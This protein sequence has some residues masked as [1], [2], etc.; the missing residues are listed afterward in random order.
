LG[1]EMRLRAKHK[2]KMY[3]GAID[4]Q[5]LL[6]DMLGKEAI[7]REDR[8][9]QNGEDAPMP[10]SEGAQMVANRILKNLKRLKKW[11]NQSGVTCYRVYDADMPEYAAAIDVYED[12]YHVQEY[13]APKS[14]N[15]KKAHQRFDEILRAT[16][17]VFGSDF[18][19][20]IAKTRQRNRGK[21]QYQ[22]FNN[23]GD[24]TYF[25]VQ[26]DRAKL[27]VN[28]S[29]YLDTGLFLDHRPLRRMILQQANGKRFLN[30]FCY[31]AT[32]TVQ[33]ALG[34][35]ASSVSV[36]MS[37]TYLDWAA[38]N[39]ELN[40]LSAARHKLVR[41]DGVEW[42]R[43]C[44]EGF[45]LIMLDPPTFSNSK[46]TDTVLD[47]QR[48]HSSLI[49]RC[50]DLLTPTGTLYF[51]NNLRSFKLDEGLQAKFQIK[52]ISAD[53]LDPDFERNPKIHNCW[54]ICHC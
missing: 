40:N 28:L 33:A 2:Y 42:L 54:Q 36:D 16:A 23:D 24:S 31:T 5:L 12:Y 3:N 26:E 46:N 37:N 35:A 25:N 21:K 29:D 10:L 30:L 20:V 45:D 43:N 52:N 18:D 44:R 49:L 34:G 41:A 9:K 4:S 47:I 22:K 53:S 39:F 6:F 50:M 32:A 15:E 13:Q 48:D 11:L 17:Q 38:R 1:K 27:L 19:H 7:L 51:S 14:V 8:R